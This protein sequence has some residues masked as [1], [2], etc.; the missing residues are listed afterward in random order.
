VQLMNA[1][2][3]TMLVGAVGLFLAACFAAVVW[4]VTRGPG[5]DGLLRVKRPSRPQLPPPF[6]PAR[7]Q[8]LLVSSLAATL[9][10]ARLLAGERNLTLP[11]S[12]AYAFLASNST[13]LVFKGLQLLRLQSEGTHHG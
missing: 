4:Q 9:L 12:M 1:L 10:V 3:T 8:M 2:L 5:L 6:S 7:L 13:Y 11:P